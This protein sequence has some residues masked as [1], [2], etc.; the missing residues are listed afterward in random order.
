VSTWDGVSQ[1]CLVLHGLR[2]NYVLRLK[3]MARAKVRIRVSAMQTPTAREQH[4]VLK[5]VHACAAY[6]RDHRMSGGGMG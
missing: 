2:R 1:T 4:G 6:N 3:T 5:T